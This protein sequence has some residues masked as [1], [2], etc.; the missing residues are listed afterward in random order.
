ML[1]WVVMSVRKDT[2]LSARLNEVLREFR[3]TH[4]KRS[5]EVGSDVWEYII[6]GTA[7]CTIII[8]GGAGSTA[9]S[10]FTVNAALESSARVLSLGFRQPY[11]TPNESS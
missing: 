9:E 2:D 4:D 6:G 7:A 3:R 10:M 8:V 11:Q 5:L 1:T